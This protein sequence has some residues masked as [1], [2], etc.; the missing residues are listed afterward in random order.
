MLWGNPREKEGR[1]RNAVFRKDQ[2]VVAPR[3]SEWTGK[4]RLGME[5]GMKN[6][7]EGEETIV[8]RK[9]SVSSLPIEGR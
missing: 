8:G 9:G 5:N 4:T 6:L 2:A 7:W 3:S 1:E